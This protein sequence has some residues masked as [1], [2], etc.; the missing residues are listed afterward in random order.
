MAN[1]NNKTNENYV[2]P[3]CHN[4]P[5]EVN[6]EKLMQNYRNEIIKL[7][8]LITKN[9]TS[10]EN[11]KKQFLNLDKEILSSGFNFYNLV[12]KFKN[13]YEKKI[14]E[15]NEEINLF[16]KFYEGIKENMDKANQ[17]VLTFKLGDAMDRITFSKIN[18]LN[19]Q[20]TDLINKFGQCD[21]SNFKK[22]EE[23]NE[24]LKEQKAVSEE[25][26]KILSNKTRLGI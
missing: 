5:I 3:I 10:E 18:E 1:V 6:Q 19:M 2:C 25:M 8:E 16:K 11:V 22:L 23:E 13:D 12:D 26:K 21:V 7:M 15:L 4:Q 24:I 17:K 14:N 9:F 20:V